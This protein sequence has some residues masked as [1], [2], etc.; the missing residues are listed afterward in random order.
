MQPIPRKPLWIARCHA[1]A[2]SVEAFADVFEKTAQA[3][4]WYEDEATKKWQIEAIYP[5]RPFV[6]NIRAKIE[7]RAH[8][9]HKPVP[10]VTF[11]ILPTQDWLTENF[12]SFEPLTLGSFYLYGSHHEK[13][14][15]AGKIGIHLDA[16]TAF[17]SGRHE[18]TQGC[19][20]A[21]EEIAEKNPWQKSLDMGCGSGILT[22]AMAFLR[23]Q[24]LIIGCDCDMEAVRVARE[25]CVL[26]QQETQVNVIQ[27]NGFTASEIQAHKP[28][29]LIVANILVEPLKNMVLDMANFLAKGGRLILSGILSSQA[30]DLILLY[31]KNGFLL[32]QGKIL[33]EWSTLVFT[34]P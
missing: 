21:L 18:T 12:R 25:N 17:G 13:S 20:E 19:L 27:S 11:K 29:D 22:I 32:T 1:C 6:Q 14:V 3:V 26:N 24:S 9:L 8:L 34:K 15:P 33:G 4:S 23:P 5:S 10:T 16:A 28:Y 7:K 2:E 31:E 30:A